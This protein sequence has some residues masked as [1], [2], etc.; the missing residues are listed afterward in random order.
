MTEQEDKIAV[1]PVASTEAVA[2]K[3]LK[4]ARH[5]LLASISFAAFLAGAAATVP[6]VVPAV[7][8]Q[9]PL[10]H[11]LVTAQPDQPA[12]TAADLQALEA[13][14]MAAVGSAS[15]GGDTAQLADANQKISALQNQLLMINNTVTA[16]AQKIDAQAE[17]TRQ[18][19]GTIKAQSVDA[20][21][22]VLQPLLALQ[23]VSAKIDSGTAYESDLDALGAQLT[24]PEKTALL[25]LAKG[26][27]STS[28]IA[29]S[30]DKQARSLAASY[31]EALATTW[32]EKVKARLS[33]LI[34]IRTASNGDDQDM[35]AAKFDQLAQQIRHGD[36]VAA[37]ATISQL[38][39]T[40]QA[41]LGDLQADLQKRAAA[42]DAV[43]SATMRL[44]TPVG[45]TR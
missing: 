19:E 33:G 24:E 32:W 38:P 21:L 43:M 40:V 42:H 34:Y 12:V 7:G 45:T 29:D 27:L 39:T 15:Q 37:L 22:A 30:L 25:P 17:Q 23:R 18:M 8:E 20:A 2:E 1:P 13:R 14:L 44:S 9:T 36:N 35:V 6:W 31:R 26:S 16:Q 28:D 41:Q 3:P 5:F 10:Y 4:Q 11:R